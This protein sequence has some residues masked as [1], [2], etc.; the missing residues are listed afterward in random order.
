MFDANLRGLPKRM[1]FFAKVHH[2]NKHN[3]LYELGVRRGD[4]LYCKLLV[5]SGDFSHTVSIHIP[6]E[7]GKHI[8]T[9]TSDIHKD[10]YARFTSAF[11]VYEGNEDFTGFIDDESKAKAK[12]LMEELDY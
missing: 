7:G 4:I 10:S 5:K 11:I 1:K 3:P 2:M 9:L 12:Q 8:V 6:T